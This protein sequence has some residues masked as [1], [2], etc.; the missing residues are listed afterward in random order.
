[1]PTATNHFDLDALIAAVEG[2]DP[3]GQ[4]AAYAPDAVVEAFNRDHGPAAPLVL[5]GR[6]ALRAAL[7]DVAARRLTHDVQRAVANDRVGALQVR[8]TYPDGLQVLCSSTFDHE[9]GRIVRETRVE[10]WD[11]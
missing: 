1:M 6:D 4:L 9:D 5:R 2:D 11:G 8:C 7:D 10:V 3:A